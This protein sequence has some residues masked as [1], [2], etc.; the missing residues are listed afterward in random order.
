MNRL[1]P[2]IRPAGRGTILVERIAI[3]VA[4]A[5][6]LLFELALAERKYALFGGG[7]GQSHALSGAGE[8]ILFLLTAVVAQALEVGLAYLLVGL[9]LGQRTR[10]L[11]R[12]FAFLFLTIGI[13]MG[14]VVAKFEL[15][16]YF[17]DAVSFTILRNLGGGSLLDA[18][19][20]GLSEGAL[21]AQL[22][23]GVAVAWL[24]CL[25]VI[26]RLTRPTD[27]GWPRALRWRTVALL[28]AAMPV[29]LLLANAH[30]NVR[31]AVVRMTASGLV[32]QALGTLTDFDRDGYSW[33]SPLRDDAPFDASRHP[34]A[35][36]I[37]NNGVDEDELGGD[38]KLPPI[39]P[40]APLP[41]LPARPKHLV[42][43]V[44]ESTRGDVIGKRIDGRPVAPNLEALAVTGSSAREAYSHV[45]FTTASLKS[46]FTGQLE[47][48]VGAPSL[49][50]D[51][52]KAGYRIA[53]M[54]GQ[55]EEFGDISGITGM[56][57]ASN[58][59]VDAETLKADRA[60][61]FAAQGSLLV[62]ESKLLTQFDRQMGRAEGWRQPTFV[63]FNF[64]SAHFPYHHDG[65]TDRI[66]PNPVARDAI[67]A[68]NRT[69]VQRTYWNAVAYSDAMIGQVIASL[70]A[71][72]VWQDTLLVVTADHGES[73]F[74]DGFLG[75]GHRINRIQ[76]HVPLVLSQP[77]VDLSGAI[78]L[79]DYRGLILRVLA[80]QKTG[81]PARKPVLRYVGDLQE[82]AAIGMVDAAGAG[83]AFDTSSQE[84]WFERRGRTIPY[85]RLVPG[86]A[87]QRDV[88]RL[89]QLWGAE[90]WAAHRGQ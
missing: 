47:P 33:F 86:T 72:G 14:V 18:A 56:K 60:F 87:E 79:R 67:T 80:G 17:S 85:A 48:R 49:F 88:G 13:H 15:L 2:R 71:M 11:V 40:E 70:K 82:P 20:Y 23:V 35:L 39:R 69:H 26:R 54:S 59:F 46:L 53:V 57:A 65:M 74:E 30:A 68:A 61:G 31:Y 32:A 8:V 28:F 7:F 63:Y 9:W 22:L 81:Q 5:V 89:I 10:R 19:L 84:A 3:G 1:A 52:K 38:L 4:L 64:Q 16:S 51:L 73:L 45:G 21:V 62:D 43:I 78:G 77:G 58:I 90:R 37:P 34:L 55:S 76:T 36:D 42:L 29:L 66:E 6:T 83:W 75:H 44:L 12:L 50:R 27:T 41:T 25:F 24:L